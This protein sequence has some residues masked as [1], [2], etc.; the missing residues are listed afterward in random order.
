MSIHFTTIES[1]TGAISKK[2]SRRPDGSIVSDGSACRVIHGT[3]T[4][5]TVANA[6]EFAI[7]IGN[8]ASNT[9][10]V[11]GQLRTD[12][13]DV[14][15]VVP[16]VALAR[17]T[18]SATPAIART[19]EFLIYAAKTSAWMLLDVDGKYLTAPVRAALEAAAAGEP[20]ITNDP[21]FALAALVW[22]ALNKQFP[23]ITA[24]GVAIR[25]STSAGIIDTETGTPCPGND[26]CHIYVQVVDG[27]DVRRT[28]RSLH[29]R[30]FLCG[31]SW[32]AL[33]VAGHHI[34]RSIVDRAVGGPEHLAF[35]G[36]P[37]VV[38][39]LYQDPQQR[40][41]LYR[42][43]V[44]LD[45]RAVIPPF[46]RDVELAALAQLKR[47]LKDALSEQR[48]AV[49]AAYRTQHVA[50]LVSRGVPEADAQRSVDR[51]FTEGMAV[52]D[53]YHVLHFD[54]PELD[55]VTVADVLRD[56]AQYIGQTLADPIE[57]VAYGRCKAM[58]MTKRE[59]GFFI[60]SFAHGGIRYDL[61]YDAVHLR[62]VLDAIDVARRANEFA[63]LYLLAD[64][65]AVELEHLRR[66]VAAECGIGLRAISAL[67]KAAMEE[68]DQV[69]REAAREA[70]R[71]ERQARGDLSAEH[72]VPSQDGEVGAVMDL[73]NNSMRPF[74]DSAVPPMRGDGTGRIVRL[75][76]RIPDDLQAIGQ[77]HQ[78]TAAGAND[79]EAESSLPRLPPVGY[80]RLMG[81]Q[82]VDLP[83]Y[84]ENYVRFYNSDGEP[85]R[86]PAP[87]VRPFL[88]RPT[89]SALPIAKGVITT[90]LILHDG[91]L[92]AGQYF[93]RRLGLLVRTPSELTPYLPTVAHCTPQIVANATKFLLD[94]F[95]VDVSTDLTGKALTI[96]MMASIIERTLLSERPG[97]I[98]T[99]GQQAA[100]K[101]TLIHGVSQAVLGRYANA[102]PWSTSEEE[103]RKRMMAGFLAGHPLFA[104]DN[105]RAGSIISC[106]KLGL[107][108]TSP[109]YNDRILGE[110]QESEVPAT[111]IQ[112][113]T[114]N[115]ISAGGE[116]ASRLL[117]I[118]LAT[119]RLF[120]EHR[121]YTRANFLAWVQTNRVKILRAVYVIL[122][123]NFHQRTPDPQ[124]A[125]T[126]FHAWYLLVGEAVERA[127]EHYLHYYG[128]AQDRGSGRLNLGEIFLEQRRESAGSDG[129]SALHQ[130]IARL[131][132]LSDP[133]KANELARHWRDG[134]TMADAVDLAQRPT[135]DGVE[136]N[137][138]LAA[139]SGMPALTR[140]SAN[141]LERRFRVILETPSNIYGQD[142]VSETVCIGVHKSSKYGNTYRLRTI[143]G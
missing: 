74:L 88:I 125:V 65:S 136:F 79:L 30:L 104:W 134:F 22:A 91:E 82:E 19:Q 108:L 69:R 42:S 141:Q 21:R 117:V 39:P 76:E 49:R 83:E 60:N 66:A 12:L 77:V 121:R 106:Q 94:D 17:M 102:I 96:A 124:Q 72:P 70:R 62:Q 43:G 8:M 53:P 57:G 139:V 86:L 142:G 6:E 38:P 135:P 118:W 133:T 5:R 130:M 137:Q 61:K 10:V 33:D 55:D 9:A 87:Y 119:L 116:L 115:N 27:T 101:T 120:A 48:A 73:I 64:L 129:L 2:I 123:G 31:L 110:S 95:L 51:V 26:G 90:P 45:T 16:A 41:P 40:V 54:D 98:V 14:V 28:L 58:V 56:S 4:R 3:A 92:I 128:S 63:R 109:T 50:T 107:V 71:L 81:L 75:S 32:V 78:L 84:L 114:G 138:L 99:A 15:D 7:L 126:R 127:I 11:M 143:T 103:R 23:G 67:M 89:D 20:R 25:R 35:E 44:A 80:T 34:E 140:P 37:T 1:S 18:A 131:P 132:H 113:I 111:A 13:P 100:G 93:D 59:G 97:F 105:V 122:L 112:V 36:A 29:D 46:I 24:A 85:V 68:R 52:L 47:Q